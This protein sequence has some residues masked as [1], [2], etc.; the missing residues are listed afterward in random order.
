VLSQPS[1]HDELAE[2]VGDRR[3]VEPA[4]AVAALDR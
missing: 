3:R 4:R 2:I 1:P